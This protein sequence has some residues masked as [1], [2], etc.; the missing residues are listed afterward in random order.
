M[1]RESSDVST[2]ELDRNTIKEFKLYF[3][4]L[5]NSFKAFMV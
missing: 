4:L 5:I 1:N 3:N 2:Q